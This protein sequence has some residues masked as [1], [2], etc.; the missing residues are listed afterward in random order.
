MVKSLHDDLLLW[1]R[2]LANQWVE[3]LPIDNG[4]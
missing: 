1:Y 4:R 2:Q 3:A